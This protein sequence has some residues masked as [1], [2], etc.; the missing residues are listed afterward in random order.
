MSVCQFLLLFHR[1]K[2]TI[3]SYRQRQ[4]EKK[5]SIAMAKTNHSKQKQHFIRDKC[6]KKN[7][8]LNSFRIELAWKL[9]HAPNNNWIYMLHLQAYSII[10]FVLDVWYKNKPCKF[11]ERKIE[12]KRPTKCLV[13]LLGFT[14]ILPI[15]MWI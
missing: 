8:S 2:S 4:S 7:L 5:I 9:P 15:F 3:I 14:F 10:K 12:E 1:N 11:N 13:W 6:K